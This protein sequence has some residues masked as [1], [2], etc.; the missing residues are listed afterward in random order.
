MTVMDEERNSVEK[1]SAAGSVP[2]LATPEE[3]RRLVR[4]IDLRIL[5][6]TCLLY[7][8]ACKFPRRW[9]ESPSR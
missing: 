8:C 3:E 4:K 9:P 1:R 7:L 5:P 2:P 6:I